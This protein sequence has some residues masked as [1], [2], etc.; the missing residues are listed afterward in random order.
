MV[1]SSRLNSC[2]NNLTYPFP[3]VGQ[4]RVFGLPVSLDSA[5]QYLY[6][7]QNET[8]VLNVSSIT[9]VGAI[10]TA[11]T[12]VPHYLST[13]KSVTISGATET[14]YNG[15]FIVTVISATQFTYTV[16]GTPATPATGTITATYLGVDLEDATLVNSFIL[17]SMECFEKMTRRVLINTTFITYRNSW[18]CFYELRKSPLVSITSVKYNDENDTEQTLADTN[19]YTTIDSFYSK[20][21]F[22]DDFDAPKISTRDQ[23]IFVELIAGYGTSESDI[24]EDIQLAIKAHVAFLWENRGD[25]PNASDKSCMPCQTITVF[26]KYQIPE[27]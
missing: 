27:I 7:D 24:P 8:I 4:S 6:L 23:S 2:C 14:D 20:L 18:S 15:A 10:A 25:C 16:T 26:Q 21:I 11:T 19:Y 12:T 9:R 1:Y 22:I 3:Y 13:G 17:A 5:Y